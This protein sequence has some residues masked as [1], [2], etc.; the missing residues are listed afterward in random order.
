M[1]A[2]YFPILY[3]S[4]L[5][6]QIHV[7]KWQ[8]GISTGCGILTRQPIGHHSAILIRATVNS[9][10]RLYK[11]T[12]KQKIRYMKAENSVYFFSPSQSRPCLGPLPFSLP[13]KDTAIRLTQH[14]RAWHSMSSTGQAIH[15]SRDSQMT[16]GERK[17]TQQELTAEL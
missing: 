7:C 3:F 8:V 9:T 4:Y 5:D 15:E 16:E 17:G 11:P 1:S 13:L 6:L 10:P 2:Y 14:G 12:V